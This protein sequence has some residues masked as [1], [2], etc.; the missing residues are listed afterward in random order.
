MSD[1]FHEQMPKKKR[2]LDKIFNVIIKHTSTYVSDTYKRADR[3]FN[4]FI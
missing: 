4:Y 3:M 1:I 2:C